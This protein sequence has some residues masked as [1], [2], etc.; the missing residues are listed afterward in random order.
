[1]TEP[2]PTADRIDA[3]A[4]PRRAPP[5]MAGSAI[6]PVQ[7]V[8]LGHRPELAGDLLRDPSC[9][10][11]VEVVAEACMA[12][13]LARREALANR[14][15]WP[16]VP[17]GVKLSLGS[18]DGIR[19]DHARRLGTLARELGAPL[20]SEH[21][22]FTRGGPREIG[23]LTRLPY[24]KAA[25][26]VLARNV[27]LARRHLPDVPLL[28]ENAAATL[29]WPDDEFDEPDFYA[30]VVRATGCALL[31]DVGNLYANA[32]NAGHDPVQTLLR[33]PLS[34]V[35]MLHVAGGTWEDGFYFDTHADPIAPPVFALVE[36]TLAEVG[37]VPILLERD[38]GFHGFAPL[39]DELERLRALQRSSPRARAPGLDAPVIAIADEPALLADQQL[40]A[41]ALTD[42]APPGPALVQRF[43]A[44]A[45]A[46]T[47][48]ILARKR[49]DDALPHLP[50]LAAHGERMRVHAEHA[51]AGRVRTDRSASVTDAWHILADV[52]TIAALHDDAE[53]DA[54]VLRARFR[55]PIADHP[56]RPRRLPFLGRARGG[57]RTVW[58]LKG[59]GDDA[60]VH[61]LTPAAPRSR[62]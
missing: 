55:A 43:G 47:R 29:E 44:D 40:L 25:V 17:H 10:S 13:R 38:G 4:S 22:A 34:S 11:F 51:L 59:P 8:G 36:R 23:H 61:V 27:A 14:A 41:R 12:N 30:Q 21:V 45:L 9:V 56:V 32:V 5:S 58:A 62:P 24:T 57:G 60:T 39:R 54:L 35:A 18:A 52:R 50:R 16:V 3:P 2:G 42:L 46:R 1:M 26:R 31:L 28:L 49:I 48:T 53:F 15:L 6:G 37:A 33:F 7:G 20:V 19:E